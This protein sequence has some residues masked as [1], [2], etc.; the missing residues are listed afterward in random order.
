[1]KK[2]VY[3]F[4]A[5]GV[6]GLM[7]FLSEKTIILEPQELSFFDVFHTIR[8]DRP[9]PD[10]III[11]ENSR[12]NP[13]IYI[14]GID[15]GSLENLGEW[16]FSRKIHA[17]FLKRISEGKPEALFFD[18][19]FLEPTTRLDDITVTSE[20]ISIE[21]SIEEEDDAALEEAFR[22]SREKGVKVYL[23]YPMD[24]KE[25]GG[26]SVSIDLDN[27]ILEK[28]TL[29][30]HNSSDTFFSFNFVKFPLERFVANVES[31]GVNSSLSDTDSQFRRFPLLVRYGETVFSHISL[32]LALNF[33]QKEMSDII[34]EKDKMRLTD[35]S[36]PRYNSMGE[37]E[38]R[39]GED[40][41]IPLSGLTQMRI[42]FS[43]YP[44]EFVSHGQY[45]SY[46]Q[47]FEIDPSFFEGKYLF[48]GP[49]TQGISHDIWA[50]PYGPM[51]GVEFH[52]NAFNTFTMQNFFRDIPFYISALIITLVCL[53]ISLF[54]SSMKLWQSIAGFFVLLITHVVVSYILFINNLVGLY[55]T[56]VVAITLCFIITI[57]YR[58]F[59][60]EREKKFIRE[61]FTNYVSPGVV[62]EL[63]KNPRML[64]L[65]GEDREITVFFSD[66]RSFTTISEEMKSPHDL[67][68][69]L[70]D[71]LDSMTE[72]IIANDGTLDKYVGDEI[73]AFWGA[74]VAQEDH[75]LK[76]CRAACMQMKFL[77]KELQPRLTEMERPMINIGCG[78]NTGDMLVGNIGSSSR[79][80]YTIIGDN[81]NLG[82]RLEGTNKIYG[83]SILIS[84]STYL[85]VRD[86]VTAREIDEIRVKGK[87]EPVTIYELICINGEEET[88]YL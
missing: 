42:N 44:G 28:I 20:G 25:S 12:L 3:V 5:L 60:E 84:E 77:R 57:L 74:P 75:A 19:L 73:M 17:Q 6:S 32:Q 66:I 48:V 15:E 55:W 21:T 59:V 36:I 76:A 27:S 38:S 56:P 47:V 34:L 82:A 51:Y 29:P 4:I 83:T 31:I 46:H 8:D 23:A 49:Y 78:L 68:L 2:L 18:T 86:R 22:A 37:I 1:M 10:D 45:L 87:K 41:F 24:Q 16:P 52:A 50:S 88:W 9:D 26:R 71:Y 63:L 7:L 40:V 35:V 14:I 85:Q 70:N 54:F 72:I 79:M 69:L 64:E 61:R 43:G 11:S 65:G 58:I 30:G 80:D 33:Y 39:S 13:D 62:D 81:V 67:V 53:V